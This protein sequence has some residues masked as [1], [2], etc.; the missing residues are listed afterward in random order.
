M[1]TDQLFH[2][3]KPIIAL[4][5][6]RALPGDPLYDVNGG[7]KRVIDIARKELNDLQDG[8]VDG[9]LIA[10]EYS[11][12]YEPKADYVTVAAMA[13]VIGELRSELRVP[14]GV[15]VVANP[16]ATIELAVACEASFARAAFSGAYMGEAGIMVT[17]PATVVRRRMALHG[18]DIKMLYKV[19]PESDAYLVERDI[20]KVT[21]SIIFHC[22]PDG[23]CVSGASAGTETDDSIL[24]SVK[25]VAGE[26]PVFCNTGCTAQNVIDKL[27]IADG[28]CVGTTFKKNGIF[29]NDVD[30]NR[31]R[32]FMDIVKEY[33]KSLD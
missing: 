22:L 4:L 18:T 32:E 6:L 29:S 14:Y 1:W 20:Q 12:P 13:R 19:N 9:I 31:V 23:L 3:K 25:A 10:N 11:M 17:D 7:M 21:K 27:K 26:V 16:L 30:K 33:R 15:G 5:H 8:G 28:V 24:S 2:V